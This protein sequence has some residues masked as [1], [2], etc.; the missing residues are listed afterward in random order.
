M[1]YLEVQSS[2]LQIISKI[3]VKVTKS[4][5]GTETYKILRPGIEFE[6][7]ISIFKVLVP[8]RNF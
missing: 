1:G 6:I 4:G 7:F 2:K 3:E 5:N 8:N